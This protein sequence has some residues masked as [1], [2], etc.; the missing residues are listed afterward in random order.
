[1]QT[2]G[3]A[4]RRRAVRALAVVA[5]HTQLVSLE[6]AQISPEMMC[7]HVLRSGQLPFPGSSSWRMQSPQPG[8]SSFL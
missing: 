6:V 2:E 3:K 8:S 5:A 1:M 7:L 4:G